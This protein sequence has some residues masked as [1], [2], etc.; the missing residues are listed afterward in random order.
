M[1]RSTPR[2]NTSTIPA[3]FRC[4][5]GA[6]ANTPP[7]EFHSP[8]SYVLDPYSSWTAPCLRYHIDL[9][10]ARP[11]TSTKLTPLTDDGKDGFDAMTPPRFSH[12][13]QV[14][15]TRSGSSHFSW[16]CQMA[17]FIPRTNTC[18]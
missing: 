16:A 2:T 11:Y 1:A 8:Q 13:A 3:S 7:S 14:L 5:A 18:A 17:R 6:P 9:S 15:S 12:L 4:T 10:A